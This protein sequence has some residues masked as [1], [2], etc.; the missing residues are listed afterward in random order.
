[1]RSFARL[2]AWGAGRYRHAV[3]TE[4]FVRKGK[5]FYE[6]KRGTQIDRR[7]EP[8]AYNSG[9]LCSKRLSAQSFPE[10]TEKNKIRSVS[11]MSAMAIALR[12]LIIVR[13]IISFLRSIIVLP[14][15][16]MIQ[17]VA[18]KFKKNNGG[19]SRKNRCSFERYR[20]A[21]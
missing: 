16:V 18:H 14:P 13:S 8:P 6:R 2:G 4:R 10:Q 20:I 3:V 21:I 11:S 7:L 5:R 9:Q 19:I 12:R 1:M 17:R 15:E